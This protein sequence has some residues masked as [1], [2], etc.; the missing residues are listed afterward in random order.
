MNFT[1]FIR[2]IMAN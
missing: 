1:L 2:C